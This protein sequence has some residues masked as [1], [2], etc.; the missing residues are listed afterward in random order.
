MT[1]RWAGWSSPQGSFGEQWWNSRTRA[2]PVGGHFYA[3]S[4][5]GCRWVAA[6][7]REPTAWNRD[8]NLGWSPF[9]L[10]PTRPTPQRIQ[11]LIHLISYGLPARIGVVPQG[12]L[13][14]ALTLLMGDKSTHACALVELEC[15]GGWRSAALVITQATRITPQ[16]LGSSGAPGSAVH[17]VHV[18]GRA[19]TS[20]LEDAGHV[21]K[22]E[23]CHPLAVA[24]SVSTLLLLAFF[25]SLA[26]CGP[27]YLHCLPC[28][29][30]GRITG[31][32]ARQCFQY[33]Y[34]TPW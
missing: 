9:L 13:R 6:R 18:P 28:E 17:S 24:P 16:A 2:D 19:L 3:S 21:S 11:P 23:P 22:P 25:L 33:F 30:A 20:R 4:P 26:K 5:W 15:Q 27:S 34:S 8:T 14:G 29:V 12:H 10:S 1:C 31:N 7:N 32:K